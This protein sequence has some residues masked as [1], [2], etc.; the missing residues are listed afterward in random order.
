MKDN[1]T[2]LLSKTYVKILGIII[3]LIPI[4]LISAYNFLLFH[5]ITELFSIVIAIS[6]FIIGWNTRNF[7]ESSFFI[8]YGIA[9]FFIAFID[10][11]HTL[12]YE[13]MNIFVGYDANLPTQLWI[14]AR[15]MQS[16]SFI[17]ALIPYKFEGNYTNLLICYAVVT[18]IML[19]LIFYGYFPDCFISASGLTNFKII[20]EY[21][22]ILF[23]L[24]SIVLLYKRRRDF[25]H[26]I[27]LL[28]IYSLI[29]TI[30]SEFA[31]T[32]YTHLYGISNIIGHIFKI[33]S[34]YFIYLGIV[35]IGLKNPIQ[36]LFQQLKQREQSLNQTYKRTN[37]YKDLFAH[38]I[39]NI[40]QNIISS[41]DLYKMEKNNVEKYH[42]KIK[43]QIFRGSNL[44]KN[45]IRLTELE[46][47]EKQLKSININEEIAKT[48]EYIQENYSNKNLKFEINIP[49]DPIYVRADELITDIFENILINA[50]KYNQSDPIKININTAKTTKNDK[51]FVKL[52]FIDNGIG[53]PP[54]HRETIFKGDFETSTKSNGLGLGLSLVKKIIE[55]YKGEIS[56][57]SRIKGNY[58]KGTNFVLM[59]PLSKS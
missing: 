4:S 54:S 37:F 56:I 55:F 45:V 25:T 52:E 53:I 29:A 28:I 1:N 36:A 5:V 58:E 14:L 12:S 46:N 15:Y 8:R 20:S 50:V 3:I 21:I 38:D 27:F 51:E 26:E 11:L 44:I 34:F 17:I 42:D 32:L 13:G 35:R 2:E 9:S 47:Y 18:L 49:E 16:I 22:I 33:I 48:V 7:T 40:F 19:F 41:L 43:N 10:L 6:I 57:Q 24:I 23:L 59:I 30:I 31:F 39:N